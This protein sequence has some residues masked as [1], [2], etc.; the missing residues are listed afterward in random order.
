MKLSIFGFESSLSF[1]SLATVS[2][3]DNLLYR[4]VIEELLNYDEGNFVVIEDN[5][6]LTIKN[7]ILIVNDVYGFDFSSRQI[8]NSL[9]KQLNSRRDERSTKILLEIENKLSELMEIFEFDS[10]ND[11]RYDTEIEL[12]SVFKLVNV[13]LEVSNSRKYI[14]KIYGI[15]NLAKRL[16]NR[17]VVIFIHQREF[18]ADSELRALLNYAE[19]NEI[20]V[21]FIEKDL[22]RPIIGEDIMVID[23]DL[24]DFSIST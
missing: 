23:K 6:R 19:S 1:K 16:M 18:L 13:S 24:Y 12:L 9:Y 8:L 10:D 15:I 2:I 4:K 17:K 21:L 7:D 11:F 3:K 5:E 22:N 14:D 20:S